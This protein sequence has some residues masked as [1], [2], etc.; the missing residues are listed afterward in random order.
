MGPRRSVYQSLALAV[1]GSSHGFVDG[2]RDGGDHLGRRVGRAALVEVEP[3]GEEMLQSRCHE[4]L[5]ERHVVRPRPAERRLAVGSRTRPR[6]RSHRHAQQNGN[7][8][9]RLRPVGRRRQAAG[10]GGGE[11]DHRRSGG[12]EAAGEALCR[13][14]G[15]DARPASG[16][17]LHQRIQD[18]PVGQPDLPAA[19]R[20]R[21]L[22]EGRAGVPDPSPRAAPAWWTCCSG[23]A[24]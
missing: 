8:L 19:H 5:D 2:F 14:P 3:L 11:E 9:C 13:L 15:G 24:G 22:Q 6:I 1:A 23:R 12:G 21:V 20:R 16:H 7:R 18:T 10:G 17:L 4:D